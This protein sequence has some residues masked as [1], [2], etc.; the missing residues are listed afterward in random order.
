LPPPICEPLGFADLRGRHAGAD[1]GARRDGL[2]KT[3]RSRQVDRKR[4]SGPTYI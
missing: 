3:T 2:A 4:C 1:S